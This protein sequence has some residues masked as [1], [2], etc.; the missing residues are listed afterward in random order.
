[1]FYSSGIGKKVKGLR[2]RKL[3]N[4]FV[5]LEKV[6]VENHCA[7]F[8]M[9]GNAKVCHRKRLSCIVLILNARDVVH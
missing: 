3:I 5:L 1:M 8:L 6:F 2:K 9:Q 4:S 7:Y